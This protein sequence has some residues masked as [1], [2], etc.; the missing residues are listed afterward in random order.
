MTSEETDNFDGR[1]SRRQVLQSSIVAA[2][3][4]PFTQT[5]VASSGTSTEGDTLLQESDRFESPH[6]VNSVIYRNNSEMGVAGSND[7]QL[8][9]IS[10]DMADL[11][12]PPV[13]S[14]VGLRIGS[15]RFAGSRAL[16]GTRLEYMTLPSSLDGDIYRKERVFAKEESDGLVYDTKPVGEGIIGFAIPTDIDA[17][18]AY[19]E[20]KQG[21]G[22]TETSIQLGREIVDRLRNPPSLEV[23]SA[24]AQVS[25][26]DGKPTFSFTVENRGD[27]SGTFR[28]IIRNEDDQVLS[29][30][31]EEI[32]SG[33]SAELQTITSE[34][35]PVSP[36]KS[37][38]DDPENAPTSKF[39]VGTGADQI[40]LNVNGS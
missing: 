30:L 22:S 16:L 8:M 24:A 32:D 9:F 34:Y 11:E 35:P 20:F 7:R 40:R 23:K 38:R 1:F 33:K 13:I 2:G 28:S 37:G 26:S 5:S 27:R 12:D 3:T 29:V 31:D 10:A 39:T 19:I 15:N 17:S 6:I 36:G 14:Q 25:K 18:E 4:I 21:N